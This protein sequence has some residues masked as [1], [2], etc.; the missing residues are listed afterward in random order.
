MNHVIR[1]VVFV[2]LLLPLAIPAYGQ[3]G[4]SSAITGVVTDSAGGVIPGATVI[5]K[6]DAT[7]TTFQSVTNSSG[8]FNVPSLSA[9]VYTVTVSLQG[10]K[11]T[12]VTDV[13]V[14]SGIPTTVNAVLTVGGVS[15]TVTVTGASA[16][17]INTRTATVASTLNVDQIA[18]IPSAT[19]DLLMGGVTFLVGR[20]SGWRR[21]RQRHDQRAARVLPEHHDGRRQQSGQLQQVD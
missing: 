7:G 21:P 3:G 11:S 16:A 10:F 9:G 12:I 18:Q 1:V 19:R 14:Q 4:A 6:S 20:E 17:L 5:A 2:A 15:E 13:R 8:A